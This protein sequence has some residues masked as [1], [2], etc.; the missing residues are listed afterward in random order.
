[1]SEYEQKK[2]SR[3][4]F[5]AIGDSVHDHLEH[6]TGIVHTSRNI[7]LNISILSYF[8]YK[9]IPGILSGDS[10]YI[11]LTLCALGFIF[12][13]IYS[14][15]IENESVFGRIMSFISKKLMTILAIFVLIY[16]LVYIFLT[17]SSA[18]L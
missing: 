14:E 18:V 8:I 10:Y 12:A 3:D 9:M 5:G 2:K 7:Y 17:M 4:I 6:R 1:M 13:G 16:F 15:Y 11:L